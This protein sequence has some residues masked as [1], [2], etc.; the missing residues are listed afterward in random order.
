MGTVD[1]A[2][3]PAGDSPVGCRQMLGNV[4]EWTASAFYP[5]P[6]YIVDLPYREYSA[7]WFGYRKVLKG[8]GFATR[9]RLVNNTYRNFFEP[10]RRDVFS[11]FRTCAL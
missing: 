7:P 10:K 4:W 6:G 9:S 3:H 5:Y 11:G 8:G 1:V 2:D